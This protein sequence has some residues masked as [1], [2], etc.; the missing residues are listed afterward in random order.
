MRAGVPGLA[1]TSFL[2][3]V[4]LMSASVKSCYENTRWKPVWKK[5]RCSRWLSPGITAARRK[6]HHR[7]EWILSSIVCRALCGLRHY[8]LH[9]VPLLWFWLVAAKNCWTPLQRNEPRQEVWGVRGVGGVVERP[10]TLSQLWAVTAPNKW[11]WVRDKPMSC[12]F[13]CE[14]LFFFNR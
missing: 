11:G 9:W 10:L 2:I 13:T 6:R 3:V 12:S 8:K 7:A 1:S 4:C 5:H 14:T